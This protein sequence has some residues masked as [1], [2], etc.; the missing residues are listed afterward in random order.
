MATAPVLIV[1][2]FCGK[3]MMTAVAFCADDTSI[4]PLRRGCTRGLHRNTQIAK[5]RMQRK[6]QNNV[7]PRHELKKWVSVRIQLE[8]SNAE[9]KTKKAYVCILNIIRD[10]CAVCDA[11]VRTLRVSTCENGRWHYKYVGCRPDMQ[12]KLAGSPGTARRDNA[13][14]IPCDVW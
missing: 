9:A 14:S 6:K 1:G 12:K 3:H 10:I 5:N 2:I 11:R 7:I 8:L 4:H 13:S